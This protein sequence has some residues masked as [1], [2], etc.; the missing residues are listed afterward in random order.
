MVFMLG[1]LAV[2]PALHALTH[3]HD[4]AATA[5]GG[6]ADHALPGATDSADTCAVVLFAQGISLA[7]DTALL[8][9][10]PLVHHAFQFPAA[11]EPLLAAA[12]YLHQPER[13]PPAV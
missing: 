13:G 9:T 1:L 8:A 10:Q 4:Q 2:N 11:E 12:R 3:A 5:H 6:D 7:T